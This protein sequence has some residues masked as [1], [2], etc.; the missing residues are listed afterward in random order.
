MG[1]HSPT[2]WRP[3]SRDTVTGFHRRDPAPSDRGGP[4]I[5]LLPC[6]YRCGDGFFYVD[7]PVANSPDWLF[8]P[9]PRRITTAHR[10]PVGRGLM[11]EEDGKGPLR[12]LIKK[13]PHKSTD[14]RASVATIVG[15]VSADRGRRDR[16]SYRRG[17]PQSA[18]KTP[19]GQGQNP[20]TLEPTWLRR[21]RVYGKSW[22]LVVTCGFLLTVSAPAV[23]AGW[24]ALSK[25][26]LKGIF[27]GAGRGA[28]AVF[29]FSP[30]TV[31]H[32]RGY[33]CGIYKVL[34][35]QAIKF[36]ADDVAIGGAA[37][38]TERSV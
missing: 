15:V 21:G 37:F 12:K 32:F 6:F 7:H 2:R 8:C 1:F 11:G 35:E 25:F 9:P 20:S 5:R 31:N 30:L 17:P 28:L 38:A 34:P 3:A 33:F 23:S 10:R 27:P 13:E 36:L 18:M 29:D 26:T 16:A 14:V 19:S 4:S 22:G 24:Q